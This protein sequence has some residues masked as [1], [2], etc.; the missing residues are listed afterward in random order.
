MRRGL[1]ILVLGIALAVGWASPGL[2][3]EE[4][5]ERTG[6]DCA[7]CHR[8]PGGG[9]PLTPT[10][11]A[12][13][14]GGYRWPIPGEAKRTAWSGPAKALRLALG[15]LHLTTAVVWFGTIFYVHLILRPRY[16]L[17]GLPKAEMRL[18]WAS[19]AVLAATGV[20]LTKMRF[21]HPSA[22]LAT[23]SGRL[24]LVKIGLFVFLVVSAAFVTLVLSPR[25]RRLQSAWQQNDGEEG[26]PA[27]V[28]VGDRIYDLT[29][30]PRWAGGVH[31]RRHR[32]GQ[33]LTEALA[34]APH[35]PEK[36]EGFPSWPAL[37]EGQE[38]RHPAKRAF[39]VLTYV[40]LLVALGV[41]VVLSLWRWG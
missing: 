26:R 6:Q 4:Y 31:V 36:L 11:E 19:M 5:A 13:S 32:A 9:G 1:A 21:H 27:W 7:L 41:L 3:T 20:P 10:G 8:D 35:G 34:Q 37:E 25:L 23:H 28:R 18:A 38:A 14:A 16:A 15:F 2:S 39:L 22:L 29:R 40:N 17:G 24:L 33:D 30:S 12:F